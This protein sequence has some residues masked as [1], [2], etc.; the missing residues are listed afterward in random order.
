M[1]CFADADLQPTRQHTQR[2]L[3]LLPLRPLKVSRPEDGPLI[4]F[5]LGI[6]ILKQRHGHFPHLP[7]CPEGRDNRR[8]PVGAVLKML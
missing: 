3:H 1:L 2:T 4:L 5:Q 6:D 7:G 8:N